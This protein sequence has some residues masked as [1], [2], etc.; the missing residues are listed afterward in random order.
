MKI[1]RYC[2]L[3]V[4]F[5]AINKAHAQCDIGTTGVAVVNATNTAPVSSGC[6]GQSFNFKFTIANF[7]SSPGCVMPANTV[8]ATFDFPTISGGIKP[9]IYNGPSSFVSGFFTWTYDAFFE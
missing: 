9:F 2:L 7:G 5:F 6:V 8:R 1:T 3:V 4:L